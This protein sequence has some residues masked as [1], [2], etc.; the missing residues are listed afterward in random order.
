M[1]VI[2]EGK[3]GIIRIVDEI[4]IKAILFSNSMPVI[5]PGPA[6]CVDKNM[7][8]GTFDCFKINDR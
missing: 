6:Q 3:L 5:H 2:H 8:M 1:V 4:H 7:K